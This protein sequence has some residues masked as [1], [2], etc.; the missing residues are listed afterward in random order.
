MARQNGSNTHSF[1]LVDRLVSKK[2]SVYC[3]T[4]TIYPVRCAEMC[5]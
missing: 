3:V 5:A 1:L 4:V 2:Q